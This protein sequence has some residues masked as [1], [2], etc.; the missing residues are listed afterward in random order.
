MKRVQLRTTRIS[1]VVEVGKVLVAGKAFS[2]DR[3]ISLVLNL[4]LPGSFPGVCVLSY[5]FVCVLI[6]EARRKSQISTV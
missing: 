6:R 2:A 1:S 3:N 4:A 5:C